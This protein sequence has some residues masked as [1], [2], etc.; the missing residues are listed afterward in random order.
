MKNVR[1]AF[2]VFEGGVEQLPSGF[3]EI[4]CHMIFDIK[5]GENFCRK[6]RLV[7]GG[8]ATEAP[9]TLTYLSVVSRDS[10]QIALTIAALNELEVMACDIQNAYLTANCREKIWTRADPE[11]GSEVG[12]VLFICKALYGL[13]SSGGAFCSHLAETLYDIGFVP[14]RADPD[15]WRRPAAKEDG[16]E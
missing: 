1:P 3:Q 16:F 15:I 10:V 13:R 14:T 8:H 7:A 6:A 2:E 5:I 9:A 12:T 4:K 11:F